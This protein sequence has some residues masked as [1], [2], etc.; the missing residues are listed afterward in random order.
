MLN[1]Q[2][3]LRSGKTL[4]DMTAEFAIKVTRHATLPLVI[5]NY[6]QIDSRPK[7]HPIIRECRCLVLEIDTWNCIAKSFNRFFNSGEDFENFMQFDW[8]NFTIQEKLDGSLIVLFWYRGQWIVCTRGTFGDGLCGDSGKTWRELFLETMRRD[9][10]I[11]PP[12]VSYVFEFCSIWNKNVRLYPEAK[13]YLLSAFNTYLDGQEP[14]TEYPPSW[15]NIVAESSD[16]DRPQTY[17][18]KSMDEIAAFISEKEQTD[19]TYEGVVI[20]DSNDVRFKVKSE[21]FVALHHLKDNGNITNP[22]RLVPLV[23]NGEID[24]VVNYLP[25][26]KEHATKIRDELDAA[27]TD[28]TAVYRVCQGIETQKEFAFAARESPLSA[29]LFQL[30]KEFGP[31]YSGSKLRAKWLQSADLITKAMY[32]K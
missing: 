16:I 32:G 12:T 21:T 8:S 18:F 1:V 7:T 2:Q 23:L 19:K 17:K 14:I 25:E 3:Y 5:L 15:S 26:I 20:R 9:P 30:R 28:L 4:A 13:V 27:Y 24:E 11:L 22:K 31:T 10:K 6:D 29:I